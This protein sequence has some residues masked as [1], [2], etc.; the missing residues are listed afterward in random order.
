MYLL[1]YYLDGYIHHVSGTLEEINTEMKRVQEEC[2][3]DFDDAAI[4]TLFEIQKNKT[5][6]SPIGVS[7]KAFYQFTVD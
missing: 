1:A 3:V 5:V 7:M 6:A 2:Y 4:W